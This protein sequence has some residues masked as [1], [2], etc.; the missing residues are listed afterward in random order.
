MKAQSILLF[1]FLSVWLHCPSMAQD[2]SDINSLTSQAA[3]YE[4]DGKKPELAR[5]YSKIGSL[6]LNQGQ[7][8]KAIESF[9]KSIKLYEE[10]GNENAAKNVC[11]SIGI[12]YVETEQFD[13]ALTYFK[14]SLRTSE[15]QGKQQDIVSDLIN[16]AQANQGKKN[17]AESN[18]ALERA[19]SIAQELS[20][21]S[22]I[23]TCYSTLSENYEK[24]GNSEKAKSYFELAAAINNKLQN[25]ELKKSESRTIQAEAESNAKDFQLRDKDQ[26]IQKI[27]REQQ[28]TNELLQQKDEVLKLRE[29]ESNARVQIELAKRKNIYLV[30]AALGFILLLVMIFLFFSF[31]Q[32]MEKKKAFSLLE[33]SNIQIIRQKK[34]IEIQRDLATSQK[35]KITDSIQ[36]AQRIQTAVLPP[37]S[38]IEK[39]L[40]EHFILFRPRDIVSGDFYWMTEKEG[41][42]IIAAVDCTGHGVPGAFMSMLGVAFLNDIVNKITINKHIRSLHANEILDQLRNHVIT[43]L[44]QSDK[45]NESK[46]GMDMALCIVDFENKQLQ[47]AGAHNPVYII[48][49][50]QLTQYEADRMPIGIYKNS[51]NGFKNQDIALEKDDQIYIFSDGYYDQFGGSNRLKMFSA[52]FRKYLIEISSKPMAEQKKLL[53]DFYD[54]WKGPNEQVDD[55]LVIGFKFFPNIVQPSV[56][57]EYFWPDKHFLIAEDADLNYI[58]LV[59]ALRNTKANVTRAING[60]DAVEACKINHFDLVLMDIRMPVMDGLEATKLIKSFKPQ[61]PV[62]AQ[63]ANAED[64]DIE[65]IKLVGCDD[66]IAKPINLKTFL[67]V[68]QKNI[69]K[70]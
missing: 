14:K 16:I 24:L 36:Y 31:K 35:K 51:S 63:T 22:M 68:I 6:Y 58:L 42:L 11:T 50:G 7:N 69:V 46:D 3:T 67:K 1:I 4:K 43:S 62:I 23:K 2:N 57:Q 49:K 20:N 8:N 12:S 21:I 45:L 41:I 48:R 54:N 47:Y 13:Q 32:L 5:C 59:E 30:I 33:Q 66:Y 61:L 65:Q 60:F 64:D 10:L 18:Q 53:S 55:V 37:V 29:K 28:L 56:N 25:D 39:V 27:S 19:R 17:Y 38:I 9:Q 70:Q 44:H 52:N 15:K 26:K 40:P 34:E